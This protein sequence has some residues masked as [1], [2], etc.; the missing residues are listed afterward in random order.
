MKKH[1]WKL[2][3][4]ITIFVV[5]AVILLLLPSQIDNY[6][7]PARIVKWK[8]KYEQI[9]YVYQA[10]DAQKKDELL[11]GLTSIESADKRKQIM[12][13]ILKP[14]MQLEEMTRI[15]LHYIPKFKNGKR[16][17]KNNF[18]YF[19]TLYSAKDSSSIIGIKDVN[20]SDNKDVNKFMI[21]IDING[22]LLPNT[23]GNDIFG[24]NIYENGTIE[25]FGA[26]EDINSMQQDCSTSGSGLYCSN[27]YLIGGEFDE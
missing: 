14:Y 4:S 2:E 9:S 22:F 6:Q 11:K 23:W 17:V 26:T 13:E 20:I 21:M 7:Q 18:Y 15:P 25:P 5:V 27:Y 19:H 1:F 24:M 3:Y 10:V 12:I 8:E 16:V